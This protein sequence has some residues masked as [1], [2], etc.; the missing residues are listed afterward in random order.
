MLS[1]E[2]FMLYTMV[3]GLTCMSLLLIGVTIAFYPLWIGAVR[4]TWFAYRQMWQEYN[5]RKDA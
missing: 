3:G 5:E 4:D 1:E 2:S